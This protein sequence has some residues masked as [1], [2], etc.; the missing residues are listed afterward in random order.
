MPIVTYPREILDAIANDTE[1]LFPPVG[2]V[3]PH[4]EG[5]YLGPEETSAMLGLTGKTYDCQV[6]TQNIADLERHIS[7]L[8]AQLSSKE[9]ELAERVT[10]VTTLYAE[11]VR[12]NAALVAEHE[13]AVS[14]FDAYT[15]LLATVQP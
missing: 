7:R 4:V 2:T 10:S 9:A 13:T 6:H 8:N 11:V 5:E 12:L 1:Y 15:E 3:A 14:Y